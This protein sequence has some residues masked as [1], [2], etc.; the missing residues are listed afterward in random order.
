MFKPTLWKSIVAG[1][2][3]LLILTPPTFGIRLILVLFLPYPPFLSY[4]SHPELYWKDKPIMGLNGTGGN[5]L[6]GFY[7][8]VIYLVWSIIQG[9][10]AIWRRKRS[11]SNRVRPGP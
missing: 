8:I 3:A 10:V 1:F 11:S 5:I 7:A 6:L 4:H 9:A 2:F